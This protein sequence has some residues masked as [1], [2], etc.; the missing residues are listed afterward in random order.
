MLMDIPKIAFILSTAKLRYLN[1]N[2]IDILSMIPAVK[3]AFFTPPYSHILL[4]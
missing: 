3:T 1:T 4:F 2:I